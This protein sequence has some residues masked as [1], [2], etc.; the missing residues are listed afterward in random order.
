MCRHGSLPN[1]GASIVLREPR[2]SVAVIVFMVVA[3][4]FLFSE[5][6]DLSKY[7]FLKQGRITKMPDQKMVQVTA[8]GDPNIVANKAFKLLFIG[9]H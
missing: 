2:A 7:E 4:L 8:T 6:P 5:E 9:R 1:T 3:A